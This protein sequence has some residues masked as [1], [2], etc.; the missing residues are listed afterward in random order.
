MI[1]VV[2]PIVVAAIVA[3]I[4]GLASSA[5]SGGLQHASS[6][7]LQEDQQS[8]T[9]NEN[10]LSREWT[11]AENVLNRQFTASENQKARDW[12]KMM[13]DTQYQRAVN[14]MKAAGINPVAFY[15]NGGGASTSFGTS[16]STASTAGASTSSAGSSRGASFVN[17]LGALNSMAQT[18]KVLDGLS[19]SEKGIFSK[20]MKHYENEVGSSAKDNDRSSGQLDDLIDLPP[21]V[22]DY[23]D[24][25]DHY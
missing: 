14:D 5:V 6:S 20:L 1:M 16:H 18:A 24:D 21:G 25:T 4:A 13:S 22:P 15:S 9:A 23:F 3:A 17:N 8:F 19:Q 11:S 2:A 7:A 12:Q 10:A